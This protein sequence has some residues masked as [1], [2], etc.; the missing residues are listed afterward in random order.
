MAEISVRNCL[1][2]EVTLQ[3]HGRFA[4]DIVLTK[5][6]IV[7]QWPTISFVRA[8]ANTLGLLECGYTACK[9]PTRIIVTSEKSY[10]S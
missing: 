1:Q 2:Y 5:V 6:E 7:A 8:L 4:R 3:R 10:E 9:P